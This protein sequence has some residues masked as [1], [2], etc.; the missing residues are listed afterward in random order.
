MVSLGVS[1]VPTY[2]WIKESID[3][4]DWDFPPR[5]VNPPL[6]SF[7]CAYCELSFFATSER[8]AHAAAHYPVRRPALYLR[9]APAPGRTV[10]RS[11]IDAS[12]VVADSCARICYRSNDSR[13]RMGPEELSEALA[14][15]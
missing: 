13:V 2:G 3:E 6:A 4:R 10:V 9:G 15:E 1:S 5:V 7:A 11:R 12:D 8:A 14:A